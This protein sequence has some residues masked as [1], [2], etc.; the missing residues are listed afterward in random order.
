MY[1]FF[2]FSATRLVFVPSGVRGSAPRRGPGVLHEGGQCSDL[3]D[4]QRRLGQRACPPRMQPASTVN[5]QGMSD[6]LWE[7]VCARVRVSAR[8]CAGTDRKWAALGDQ[9]ADNMAVP[10]AAARARPAGGP[11]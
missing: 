6:P 3:A 2:V 1:T 9:G 10:A 7:R 8:V 11:L 4:R 5:R